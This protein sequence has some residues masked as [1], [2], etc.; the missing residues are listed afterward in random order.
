M[1]QRKS[2]YYR[3]DLVEVRSRREIL[4][5]LDAEG[6][7][8]GVPFMPEMSACCGRRFRV[9]RRA[10]KTCVEGYGVR[11]MHDTVFLEGVRCDGASHDG[12]QRNCLIFWKEAWLKPVDAG[13]LAPAAVLSSA[14]P[15]PDEDLPPPR[16]NGRY[17][18]Q[19][20]ELAG[21]TSPLSRWNV[22]H[23]VRD[24]VHGELTFFRLLQIVSRMA[25]NRLLL[26]FGRGKIGSLRGT[27]QKTSKGNWG[28]Q[29]GDWIE[30]L[31]PTE[32]A[33]TLNAQG[34]NGGLSFEPD[35]T[36]HCGRRCR[37][38]FPIHKIISEETGNMIELTHTV[39]LEGVTCE[40][41]CAKNCPRS[42]PLYWRECWLRPLPRDDSP[43]A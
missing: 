9:F 35:M 36:E 38:S 43:K 15:S 39:A 14:D 10:D 19:S 30:I 5:T 29:P 21:A 41:L 11:R 40:G 4:A 7:L 12:C 42:N 20:T 17:F 37:V 8:E 27:R 22:A 31:T 28:L 26:L 1:P 25:F 34:K 13:G 23:F 6:K 3:G 32:I 16:K 18:C 24:L 33:E 2:C